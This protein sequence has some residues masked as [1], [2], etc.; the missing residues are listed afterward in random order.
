MK[1]CHAFLIG[2]LVWSTVGL[3][4]CQPPASPA[5]V[6][7]S[8]Q[9]VGGGAA[10]SGTATS[11]A[12]AVTGSGSV[13]VAFSDGNASNRATVRQLSGGAWSTVANAG[14]NSDTAS[15][16]SMAVDSSGTPWVS[17]VTPTHSELDVWKLTTTYWSQ[18]GASNFP[19]GVQL[20]RFTLDSLDH[21]WLAYVFS[22]SPYEIHAGNLSG[23]AWADQGLI[24]NG[25]SSVLALAVNSQQVPFVA[26]TDT[27]INKIAAVS[28]KP[29]SSWSTLTSPGS[30]SAQP[31]SLQLAFDGSGA[32]LI[33]YRDHQNFSGATVLRYDGKV[34]SPV[35]HPNFSPG[36]VDQL[37]L[38]V[39]PSGTPYLAFQDATQSQ[40]A[41]VMR[42]QG[43]QWVTLGAAGLG[44][45]PVS[46]LSLAFSADGTPWL[47]F[48]DAGASNQVK[49]LAYR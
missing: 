1:N 24:S 21:P 42:Y 27:S 25:P 23:T 38:A 46:S 45:G 6:A 31:G 17:F 48:L 43:S 47:A 3:A 9:L 8:W 39:S 29:S 12:L 7:A 15:Q 26:Y 35:G 40:R 49:V 44:A 4:S 19:V 41:T 5:A 13:F 32:P 2:A 20:S 22:A 16:L 34:W 30:G 37:A 28:S 11:P 33:A 18:V 36:A 14:F 10:S